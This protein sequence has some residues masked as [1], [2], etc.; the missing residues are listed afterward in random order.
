MDW[1]S[2]VRVTFWLWR[3]CIIDYCH[4][5][6]HTLESTL[7]I[8]V[9]YVEEKSLIMVFLSS[10]SAGIVDGN[11]LNVGSGTVVGKQFDVDNHLTSWYIERGAWHYSNLAEA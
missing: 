3:S 8:S 10:V 1:L 6:M 11:V 4:L 5:I 7:T 9:G 2:I